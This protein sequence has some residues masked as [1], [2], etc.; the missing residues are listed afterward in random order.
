MADALSTSFVATR[1]GSAFAG[2][3]LAY[4]ALW[5]SLRNLGQSGMKDWFFWAPFTLFLATMSALCWW[6]TLRG[7]HPG[8]RAAIGESW[9]GGW[10]VGGMSLVLGYVGPLLVWQGATLGPLLGILVTGPVGF[11]LG[12]LGAV[13]LRKVRALR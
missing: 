3:T 13:W 8:S 1:V 9:K 4:G 10:V 2:L 5:L 6:F 7:H 11:A 12:A